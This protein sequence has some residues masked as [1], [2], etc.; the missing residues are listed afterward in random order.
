ML[1]PLTSCMSGFS[2]YRN[3]DRG[4]SSVINETINPNAEMLEKVSTRAEALHGKYI[5]CSPRNI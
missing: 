4:A 2:F 1:V 3:V 5:G